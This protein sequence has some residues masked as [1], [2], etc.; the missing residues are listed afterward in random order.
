MPPKHKA[1]FCI[2]ERNGKRFWMRI[3]MAFVNSDQSLNV[4]LD[5]FPVSG[6]LHIRDDAPRTDGETPP[7][8]RK[9]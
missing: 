6:K 2:V 1:V 3:G 4:R 7:P 8:D 5:A 9:S